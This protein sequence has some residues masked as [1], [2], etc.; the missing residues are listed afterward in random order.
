[1]ARRV[2]SLASEIPKD[3]SE[4]SREMEK[5]WNF[6]WCDAPKCPADALYKYRVFYP[7]EPRC[8]ARKLHRLRLWAHLPR[9]GLFPQELAG[10]LRYYGTWEAFLA[11]K[12]KKYGLS[13]EQDAVVIPGGCFA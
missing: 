1:M 11:V 2:V 9:H 10:V 4:N 5:C 8:K 7:G 13:K 6:E 12:G 3:T